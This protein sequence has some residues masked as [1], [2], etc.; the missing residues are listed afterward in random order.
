[1]VERRKVLE[2]LA[3]R[4]LNAG[5]DVRFGHQL[6]RIDTDAVGA[7]ITVRDVKRD[8]V[9]RVRTRRVIG[10]DGVAS[11][12]AREFGMRGPSA[13]PLFQAIVDAPADLSLDV[14]QVWFDTAET[15]Y[16]YWVISDAPGRASV[17][18][19]GTDGRRALASLRRFLDT[20]GLRVH[21][22]Q[23]GRIP[24]SPRRPSSWRSVG[25]AEVFL[26]GDAAGHVKITTVGGLVTGLAGARAAA[27]A[28][29]E[30]V[31]YASRLRSLHRELAWHRR[32]R[33][34]LDR[35]CETDYDDLL[36]LMDERTMGILGTTTRDELAATFARLIVTQ[37]RLLWFGR[38]FLSS[39]AAA[40]GRGVEG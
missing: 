20:R 32:V 17:G 13:V 10:A 2:M 22:L 16:F 38:R 35:F 7:T 3:E 24:L 36:A 34:V 29:I 27:D 21:E 6:V 18:L 4:A 5:V 37:P 30:G 28:I 25:G 1:V 33:A 14:T 11:R 15:P 40:S 26:V 19:I 23:A 39:R 12:V 31:P 8:R 9:E